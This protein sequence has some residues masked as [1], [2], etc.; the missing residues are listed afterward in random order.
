MYVESPCQPTQHGPESI[1]DGLDLAL[2]GAHE[3][4]ESAQ[5]KIRAHRLPQK[6]AVTNRPRGRFMRLT[7]Y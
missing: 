7:E 4:D 1:A 5:R 2:V 3:V 6:M